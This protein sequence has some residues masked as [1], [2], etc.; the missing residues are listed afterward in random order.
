MAGAGMIGMAV[1]DYGALDRSNGVDME[2]AWLASQ[3]GGDR[4][5][6]VLRAHLGY[7]GG[8]AAV[9]TSPRRGEVAAPKRSEGVAGE[10]S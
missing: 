6:D 10:G 1:G 4:H 8:V 2:A 9:F 5:Q 3:A 7:I